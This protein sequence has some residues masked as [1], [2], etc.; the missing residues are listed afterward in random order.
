MLQVTDHSAQA[1]EVRLLMSAR[2]GPTLFD[3]RCA[4][5]EHM[6]DWIRREMPEALVRRRTLQVAPVELAAG[7]SISEAVAD[8]GARRASR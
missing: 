7:P 3:L 1:M 6:L 8:L 2:D 5:R 4:M